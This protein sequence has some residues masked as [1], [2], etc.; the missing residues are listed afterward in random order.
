MKR[1]IQRLEMS[2]GLSIALHSWVPRNDIKKVVH[3]SH[4]MGEHAPRY[5]NFAQYLNNYGIAVYAHD[6]RGH[7]QSIQENAPVGHLA[8]KNGFQR[9]TEDLHEI[10]QHTKKIHPQIPYIVLGH[11]FGSFVTQNYIS[12]YG[13]EIDAVILSGTTA[14]QAALGKFTKIFANFL[15]LFKGIRTQSPLLTKIAFGSYNKK[16]Q[17]PKSK[18]SWLSSN[19]KLVNAYDADPLCGFPCSYGFYR[20]LG[21]GFSII[22]TKQKLSSIPKNLRIFLFAGSDDP[23]SNYSKNVQ[24]LFERYKK[25][26]LEVDLKIYTGFRHECLNEVHN[27]IVYKDIYSF[28]NLI[29]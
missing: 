5:D 13:N 14:N 11:S 1:D 2:D 20:D 7:G 10:I 8:D 23:V 22:N 17:N 6:H 16:I 27:D 21:Y 3:I 18:N 29:V 28:L 12:K 4:G 15:S 9:V 26:G 19:E 24:W 25:L